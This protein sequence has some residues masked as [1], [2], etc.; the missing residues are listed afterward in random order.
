MAAKK[1]IWLSYDFGLK[2]NYASL[3]RFLD[4]HEA[5]DCGNGLAYFQYAN[6]N[7]LSSEALIEVLKTDLISLVDPSPNDRIYVIWRE[8]LTS[9][10]KGKFL[11]GKRKS[12][13]WSGYGDSA[14]TQSDEAV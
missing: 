13:P 12:A 7:S 14:D 3:F 9:S 5:I 1:S 4:N 11:F 6:P 10:V 8:E 2:G